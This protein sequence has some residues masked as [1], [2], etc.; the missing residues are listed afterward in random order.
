MD[1]FVSESESTAGNGAALRSGRTGPPTRVGLLL[2]AGGIR[3]SA[4]AGVLAILAEAGISADIVVGASI[5]A[6]FGA[7]DA[8]GWE[9]ARISAL[10]DKAPP[11]AVGQ[12]YR[13]R[14][15]IDRST[16]VGAILSELGEDTRIEDLEKPFAC[17]ALDRETGN[18][19]T[20]RNG[21]L[22]RSLEASIALPGIAKPVHLNGRTFL[23]GGMKG[24]VPAGVAREMGAE[25]VIRV[26]LVGM[27]ARR[28]AIRRRYRSAFGKALSGS[29]PGHHGFAE[30]VLPT[31]DSIHDDSHDADLVITPRFFGLFCSS[32]VGVRFCVRQGER[33]T[34]RALQSANVG[35][36]ALAT[37]SPIR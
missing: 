4:H 19:V 25:V 22:L 32:P 33:A 28:K 15:R 34:R 29:I 24:P 5:G 12:F 18:V 37:G 21:P 2:G 6:L 16:Y 20:L 1:D 36:T 7:A 13:N 17:M 11:F 31:L 30:L 35:R 10:A 3:G 14:L 9:P 23:D 27:G 26:E 8:A